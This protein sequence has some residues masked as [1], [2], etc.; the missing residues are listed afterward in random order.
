MYFPV[1]ILDVSTFWAIT[2]S[3]MWLWISA[4]V[5]KLQVW[6]FVFRKATNHSVG[7]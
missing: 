7:L 5:V 1:A 2:L 3:V 4:Y 6:Y